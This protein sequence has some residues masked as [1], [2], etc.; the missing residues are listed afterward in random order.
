M[1]HTS[2]L[3]RVLVINP[4]CSQPCSGGIDAAI[5]P[6]RLPGGPT[7]DVVTLAEGPPGIYSW[8]DWHSVVGPLCALVR[9]V[10]A[11]AYMVACASD[12]GIEAVRMAT[13]RPVLGVFRSAVAAAVARGER[14]GVIALVD[15]SKAR[16]LAALRAMG[17]ESRLAAE[18]A[19]NVRIETLLDEQAARARLIGTARLLVEAG[20]HSVILGCTGMAHHRSWIEDAVG[21]AVIEPC[22]AA[23]AQALGLLLP[24]MLPMTTTA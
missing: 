21:V 7:L 18:I 1:S 17:L 16:H 5:A 19:L 15:A 14:F 9:R 4:N 6:F 12:P 24:A 13:D 10:P 11:D 8:Q 2:A 23:A 3:P 22:Q 20:A